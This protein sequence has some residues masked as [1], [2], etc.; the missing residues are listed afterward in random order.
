MFSGNL[1]VA[2]NSTYSQLRQNGESTCAGNKNNRSAYWFPALLI[3]LP[4][5]YS[6]VL[7][8]NGQIV[9][10]TLNPASLYRKMP[11]ASRATS[12]TSAATIRPIRTTPS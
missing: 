8:F 5:G 9:Y 11:A 12:P 6:A 10:Y 1:S 4:T 3:D 7:K 2:Y